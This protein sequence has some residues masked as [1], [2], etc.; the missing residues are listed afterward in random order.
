MRLF[1]KPID[2]TAPRAPGEVLYTTLQLTRLRRTAVE[3]QKFVIVALTLIVLAGALFV[4]SAR[5]NDRAIVKTR[6]EARLAE[7]RRDNRQSDRA[8]EYARQQAM[9]L[10]MASQRGRDVP[11]ADRARA[12]AYVES[13][14]KAARRLYPERSCSQ[15][16]IERY[17]EADR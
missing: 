3:F 14:L 1:P 9:V 4:A 7:C 2:L 13:S 17:Y 8:V 10:V 6:E 15:K 12:E 11:A 16:A 5:A